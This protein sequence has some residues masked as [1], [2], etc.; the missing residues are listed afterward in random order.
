MIEPGKKLKDLSVRLN[1]K[2]DS[3]VISAIKSLRNENPFYGAIQLLAETFNRCDNPVIKDLIRNFMNDVKES[4]VRGEVIAEIRK[5][6][7]PGTIGMLVSSCWQSGLDYTEYAHDLT[8]IFIKSDYEVAVECFTVIEESAPRV[9]GKVRAEMISLL[10][11]KTAK[12]TKE[13]AALTL[14]L[15]SVLS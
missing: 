14:E 2:N 5:S 12:A 8:A 7:S 6:Y 13:K 9:P 3:I 4:G 15:I 11:E 1:D 10:K